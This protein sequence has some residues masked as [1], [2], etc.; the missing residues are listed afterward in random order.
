MISGNPSAAFIVSLISR[1]WNRSF[2]LKGKWALFLTF[3]LGSPKRQ[4]TLAYI[5][6]SIVNLWLV[7]EPYIT[8]AI[9]GHQYS[10]DSRP[11]VEPNGYILMILWN[12]N[13]SSRRFGVRGKNFSR[14][15]TDWITLTARADK[16]SSKMPF[17]QKHKRG[18]E[19]HQHQVKQ[20]QVQDF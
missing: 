18:R 2:K 20:G 19:W 5:L 10:W 9:N 3:L 6:T 12:K 7:R 8:P 4:L 17:S 1:Y 14:R 11:Y 15:V 16:S 13:A